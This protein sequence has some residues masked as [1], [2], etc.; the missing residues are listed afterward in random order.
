MSADK[1]HYTYT[2]TQTT[3]STGYFSCEPVPLPSLQKLAELLLE[4]PLDTFLRRHALRRLG[5]L[6]PQQLGALFSGVCRDDGK[7]EIARGFVAELA[8]IFPTHSAG[9]PEDST[10]ADSPL[11]TLRRLDLP[12]AAL[13][14]A[15]GA[16]FSENMHAHRALRSLDFSGL[17][18]LFPDTQAQ[19]DVA[20]NIS[21]AVK[22]FA[23]Q[24]LCLE[25]PVLPE[26][27][28]V[29]ELALTRLKECGIVA[30]VEQRH[31]ASLSPVGLLL[32]WRLD[33]EVDCGRHQHV[34]SGE[35]TT[36]GRGLTVGQ[37]RVS[38][39]ME[40][41]ERASAYLSVCGD[42]VLKR[43]QPL[44]L[45]HSRLSELVAEG[46][47]TLDPNTCYLEAPYNDEELYWLPGEQVHDSVPEGGLASR[48]FW[49]PFQMVSLFPNLDEPDLCSAPGSTGLASGT[50]LEQARLAALIEI[51]ERDTEATTLYDKS[52][53]FVLEADEGTPEAVRALLADYARLGIN[54]QFMDMTGPLGIPCYQCF[55]IGP[56]GSIHAGYGAGLSGGRAILSAMTE[57]PYPY[58]S[59]GPSGPLLRNLP[60]KKFSQLPDYSLGGIT[61]DLF[62]LEKLL[63]ANGLNPVYVNLTRDDLRLPVVRAIVPGM[64]PSADFDSFSRLSP[65]LY[66]DYLCLRQQLQK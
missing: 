23:E 20:C 53:C 62:V 36:Y 4:R 32:P 33:V 43:E 3:S 29:A 39:R 22:K 1:L 50:G 40:M 60:V 19:S 7:R 21:E 37:A 64:Q 54:V 65:R 34:L 8:S 59:G 28:D 31:V 14:A 56:R 2:H 25:N 42:T 5:E 58:P 63:C 45:R 49:V 13:H 35:A 6:T 26:L 57:T 51:I 55:V 27:E 15:W 44:E 46:V 48:P 17:E 30:G 47:R 16:L 11:V 66:Q 61:Q 41:V 18:P 12:D 38:C 10:R 52:R 9:L 24:A